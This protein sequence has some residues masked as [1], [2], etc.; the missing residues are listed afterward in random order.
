M[1]DRDDLE[2]TL[3]DLG[4]VVRGTARMVLGS[5]VGGENTEEPVISR[6]VDAAL[7]GAVAVV[8]D[9]LQSVGED[10]Q[11]KGGEDPEPVETAGWSPLAVG[12]QAFGHGLR[13]VV[14]DFVDSVGAG[15]E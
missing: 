4:R 9:W 11:Q 13:S 14:V 1:A 6:E 2:R 3:E 8:G 15:E 7:E 10:L 5:K 12:A